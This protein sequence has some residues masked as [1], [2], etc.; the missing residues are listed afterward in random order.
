MHFVNNAVIRSRR[1][2]RSTH[3]RR[4][5]NGHVRHQR[6]KIPRRQGRRCRFVL[7]TRIFQHVC[8]LAARAR[9]T[10]LQMLTKVIR[11]EKL[12][13]LVAL[14]ELVLLTQV[15]RPDVPIGRIIGELLAA[16]ATY[17]R[18]RRVNE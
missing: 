18:R 2:I 3:R 8:P 11:P 10:V 1:P 6:A 15:L 17:V 4:T 12:L 14:A 7:H 16:I 13:G 9:M 5:T